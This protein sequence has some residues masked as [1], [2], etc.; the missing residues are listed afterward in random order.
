[1]LNLCQHKIIFRR[2]SETL[3]DKV[4]HPFG[5]ILRRKKGMHKEL[6]SHDGRK[7][8]SHLYA[9]FSQSTYLSKLGFPR[10]SRGKLWEK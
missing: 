1:M 3:L 10:S 5:E 4:L 2:V 7:D 6:V 9:R 8:Q